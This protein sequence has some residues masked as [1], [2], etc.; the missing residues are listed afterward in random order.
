MF[1]SSDLRSFMLPS[2]FTI[3]VMYCLPPVD[4]AHGEALTMCVSFNFHSKSIKWES[5]QIIGPRHREVLSCSKQLPSG[6]VRVLTT[7]HK[8]SCASSLL[9]QSS[10]LL[11]HILTSLYPSLRGTYITKNKTPHAQN[12]LKQMFCSLKFISWLSG[13]S[14]VN[15]CYLCFQ[16]V[17][18]ENSA[19][20][21]SLSLFSPCQLVRYSAAST[22]FVSHF[23]YMISHAGF[24]INCQFLANCKSRLPP[25]PA[26]HPLPPP[27]CL[28]SVPTAIKLSLHL[29][30]VLILCYFRSEQ[31]NGD[32]SFFAPSVLSGRLM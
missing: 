20:V 6:E 7:V 32:S 9:P 3:T 11:P 23:C 17:K 25:T 14:P 27:F 15:A 21:N 22:A 1:S 26:L 24:Q 19:S 13:E 8:V 12:S 29:F 4:R 31:S 18:V 30:C 10:S 28:S 16:A 2:I 5:S